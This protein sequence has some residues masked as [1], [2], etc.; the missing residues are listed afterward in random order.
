MSQRLR[1]VILHGIKTGNIVQGDI[2][3]EIVGPFIFLEG[4]LKQAFVLIDF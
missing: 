1:F 2:G 4:F 3:T